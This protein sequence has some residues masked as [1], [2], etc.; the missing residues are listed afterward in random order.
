MLFKCMKTNKHFEFYIN[1]PLKDFCTF[2]IGG[3]AKYLFIVH[4]IKGLKK[5]VKWCLKVKTKFKIIG[6]GANILFDDRGF[7]GAIIVNR[8]DKIWGANVNVVADA[9]CG[10]GRLI[11]WAKNKHLSGL[12]HFA[13]IPSSLG[14]AI[15]NNLGAWGHE[16]AETVKWVKGFFVINGK[17]KRAKFTGNECKFKYRSSIFKTN[18]FIITK[19]KLHLAPDKAE[20]IERNFKQALTKKQESQPIDLPSAGSI[21]K[22]TTVIPAKLIDESGLKGLSVG[23]A[24]I[25]IKHAGFIV[26]LSSASSQQVK[27]LIKLIQDEIYSK[28]SATLE[29][30]IEYVEF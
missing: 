4:S 20:K 6:C 21:F 10:I 30:E 28:C 12:E 19:A 22:R 26:N 25:S 17:F 13:A 23:D 14:G 7:D 16:I 8:A 15:T 9:G 1:K 18:N 24:Q 5:A 11:N 27:F 29:R 2:K 3:D